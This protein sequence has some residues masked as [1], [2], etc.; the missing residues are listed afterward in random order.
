M[1]GTLPPSA[2][3]ASSVENSN[4]LTP[5]GGCTHKMHPYYTVRGGGSRR[6]KGRGLLVLISRGGLM[7]E[8]LLE[9]GVGLWTPRGPPEARK[10]E[11]DVLAKSNTAP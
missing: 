10:Q 6:R 5:G 8:T 2:L 7:S 4:S 9:V 1:S 3:R 11:R